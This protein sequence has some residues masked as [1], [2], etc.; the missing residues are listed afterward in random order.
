MTDWIKHDRGND[1][2]TAPDAIVEVLH[3]AWAPGAKW[4][5]C[6]VGRARHFCWFV[7]KGRGEA[8]EKIKGYGDIVAWR[9]AGAEYAGIAEVRFPARGY[10]G[11][12]ERP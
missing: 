6:E 5:I 12:G 7:A 4:A 1:C 2:P 9:P 10:E 8:G 3:R 11:Q